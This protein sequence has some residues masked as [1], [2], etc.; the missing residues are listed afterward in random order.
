MTTAALQDLFLPDDRCFGC[1]PANPDGLHLKT[2]E[3]DGTYTAEWTPE[4]R[5]EGPEGVVNGGVMAIPMDCHATWAAMHVFSEDR[6]GA[7]VG[8]VTAEYYVRLVRPTPLGHRV[9]LVAEVVERDEHRARVHVRA[10][11][12]DDDV[13]SS[14]GTYVCVDHG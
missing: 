4:D 11:V 1:G 10:S 2:Y 7:P 6:G 8:A 13:A 12:E 9:R 5:F 3:R 14:H